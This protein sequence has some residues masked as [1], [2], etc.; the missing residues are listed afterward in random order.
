MT[1]QHVQLVP[2]F[3]ALSTLLGLLAMIDATVGSNIE[4]KNAWDDFKRIVTVASQDE[5]SAK[6]FGTTLRH[7]HRF[8]SLVVDIDSGL[9]ASSFGLLLGCL[10][11]VRTRPRG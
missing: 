2:A 5:A 9:M 6:S 7:L 11:Q 1:F 3:D 8:Q 4:L 10:S